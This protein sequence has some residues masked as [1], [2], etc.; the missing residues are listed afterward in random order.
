MKPCISKLILL[1]IAMFAFM[2][3]DTIEPVLDSAFVENGQ[4]HIDKKPVEQIMQYFAPLFEQFNALKPL[5]TALIL[6][7]IFDFITG[8]RK[9][10]SNGEEINSGGLRRSISK[11]TEYSIA[12]LASHIFTW[13]F[14][15]DFFLSY[16]VALYICG[17]ELKSIYE[18]V[19][20]TTGVGIADYFKGFIPDVKS[21]ITKGKLNNPENQKND[22]QPK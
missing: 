6:L 5:I 18:N 20:E 1:F 14:S 15:L 3:F 21:M 9:A 8:T 4:I 11:L 7:I 12:V 17:I 16:Y 22:E 10:K 13:M 2:S 19:S